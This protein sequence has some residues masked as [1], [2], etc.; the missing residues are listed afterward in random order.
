[1]GLADLIIELAANIFAFAG[2]CIQPKKRNEKDDGKQR[3]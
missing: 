2:D 1:M 3:K